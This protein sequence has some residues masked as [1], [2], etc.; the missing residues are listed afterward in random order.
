MAS[1]NDVIE[2]AMDAAEA[3]LAPV[4][5]V[6]R[7]TSDSDS[8]PTDAIEEAAIAEAVT[9]SQ[10]QSDSRQRDTTGKFTKAPAQKAAKAASSQE[11]I[12]DHVANEGSN[13]AEANLEDT[14]EAPPIEAPDFWSA[15][16][17]QA[18]AKAPRDIQDVVARKEAQR[19]EWANRIATEA[20]N[21]KEF[22]KR[23][24]SDMSSQDEVQRHK[25]QLQLN[26]IRDEVEELHRYRAWDKLLLSDP[27]TG[28]VDLIR[29]NNLGHRFQYVEDQGQYSPQSQT[30]PRVDEALREAQ[31]AK[32]QFTSW[33]ESQE[34]AARSQELEAFK[35]GRDSTGNQRAV[36]V[37]TYAPQI[38]QAV[39]EIRTQ[40]P[41]ISRSDALNHGY[42]FVLSEVRKLHG[43]NS[44]PRAVAPTRPQA[45]A[46]AQKAKAAA[47]GV[48]GAP[49]NGNTSTQRPR[50][51]G[52]T[53]AQK[54]DAALDNVFE[55]V[56]SR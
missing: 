53:F 38:A 20:R 28:I 10:A 35:Q 29:K 18:F 36:F 40:Y 42:E 7:D 16:E 43:I 45:P 4:E 41:Q 25:A 19:N 39:K 13:E 5:E 47:T 34:Q 32:Q 11:Q 44:A 12:S 33:Q 3:K 51:K 27:E 2:R 26:G 14:Q 37:D 46:S 24:Y 8:S 23:L 6:S 31:E 21:G 17:K 55:Q 52:D 1:D 15:A 50:L 30:D 56:G 54:I 22:E 9:E 48:T 49:A